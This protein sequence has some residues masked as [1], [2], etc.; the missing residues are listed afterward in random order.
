M[1]RNVT[2][3]VSSSCIIA[4]AG[5]HAVQPFGWT[6][7]GV[8]RLPI[9]LTLLRVRH[10]HKALLVLAAPLLDA[11]LL[12]DPAALVTAMVAFTLLGSTVYVLNDLID[13][14]RDAAHP[15]KQK[16]PL[17]SGAVNTKEATV[18]LATTGTVAIILSILLG[19]GTFLVAATYL[20]L[21]TAYSLRLKHVPY[22]EIALVASGYPVRVLYGAFAVGADHA[23]AVYSAVFL[24]AIGLVTGKRL[25]ESESHT[26][27]RPVLDIYRTRVLQRLHTLTWVAVAVVVWLWAFLT[28]DLVGF[29]V[30]ALVTAFVFLMLRSPVSEE[31]ERLL[32]KHPLLA[33]PV[34]VAALLVLLKNA[35]I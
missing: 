18:L 2:R 14:E 20:T 13:R 21:Q 19:A 35:Q 1:Q 26:T 9:Y 32:L 22:L 4:P 5:T 6:V 31:P 8:S 7:P 23:A 10:A 15:R 29:L 30:A 27:S 28:G 12:T 33:L 25:A 34:V 11:K 24:A 16:R 17:A 3:A